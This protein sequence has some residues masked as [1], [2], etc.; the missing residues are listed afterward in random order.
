MLLVRLAVIANVLATSMG[1]PRAPAQALSMLNDPSRPARE[2]YLHWSSLF[3]V[4]AATDPFSLAT[5]MSN[6]AHILATNARNL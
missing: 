4:S 6:D 3:N 5:W 2:R 1:A